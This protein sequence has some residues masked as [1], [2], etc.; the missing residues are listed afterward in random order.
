MK[1]TTPNGLTINMNVFQSHD[2]A[3]DAWQCLGDF[4]CLTS[5][6][7]LIL[8]AR[9]HFSSIFSASLGQTTSALRS[10]SLTLCSPNERLSH[11]ST[12]LT[13]QF[14]LSF[15][16]EEDTLVLDVFRLR[17][18]LGRGSNGTVGVLLT[19]LRWIGLRRCMTM[20]DVSR[21][22]DKVSTICK[23]TIVLSDVELS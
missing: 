16:S 1:M 3:M 14:G 7:L 15:W 6:L 13:C 4:V 9:L 20:S 2:L 10:Q 23:S 19:F 8:F 11:M 22:N 12:M 18:C 5:C 21:A 17:S